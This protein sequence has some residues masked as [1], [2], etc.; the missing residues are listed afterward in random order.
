MNVTPSVL[1]TYL[2]AAARQVLQG[3]E[4]SDR[5]RWAIAHARA[6]LKANRDVI[7][8]TEAFLTLDPSAG[9]R[10]LKAREDLDLAEIVLSAK[11]G[12]EAEI[13]GDIS[14]HEER[15]AAELNSVIADLDA[16]SGVE[17]NTEATAAAERL[18][19]V[20]AQGSGAAV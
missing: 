11:A 5:S 3:A 16:V 2:A 1:T 4:L 15:A 8:G 9:V 19:E 13:G 20:F 12:G 17:G 6:E 18:L 10:Q 7:T 14:A